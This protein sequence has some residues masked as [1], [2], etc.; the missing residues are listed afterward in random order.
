VRNITGVQTCALP[1]LIII[2][3][4]ENRLS[5]GKEGKKEAIVTGICKKGIT[6]ATITMNKSR[7]YSE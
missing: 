6:L 2:P 5:R 3:W 7:L 1:I 4:V